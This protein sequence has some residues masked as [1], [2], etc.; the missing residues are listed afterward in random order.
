M[1]LLLDFPAVGVSS[2]L[3]DFSRRT[4]EPVQRS[5]LADADRDFDLDFIGIRTTSF[6]VSYPISD[7]RSRAARDCECV[8]SGASRVA[9]RSDE[10]SGTPALGSAFSAAGVIT[11]IWTGFLYYEAVHYRVHFSLSESGFIARQRRRHFYHHFTNN[12]RGFGVT[13]PLWDHVFGTTLPRS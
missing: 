3:S 10:A 4:E 1:S 2:V 8:T 7:T 5:V 6:C 9:A 13:S 12:K 11:G